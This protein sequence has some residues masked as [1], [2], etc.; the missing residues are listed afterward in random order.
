MIRKKP[1]QSAASD[2]G[3]VAGA[4]EAPTEADA[5]T[6]ADRAGPLHGPGP[7]EEPETHEAAAI[8]DEISDQLQELEDLKE[9]HLRLAAEFENYRKRTRRELA[10]AGERGQAS[11]VGK[12]L[13]ALDDLGR[14][15]DIPIDS[16][17]V[18]A[19]HEG[20]ALVERKLLKALNDAGLAV[21]EADGEPFD[22][23]LHDALLSVPTSDPDE[24]DTVSQVVTTGYVFRDR[25]LRPAKVVV[26]N[27]E[28]TEDVFGRQPEAGEDPDQPSESHEG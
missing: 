8:S 4:Q 11:L 16:T 6:V 28:G 27:L 13:D 25:L 9:R 12:L 17:T 7:A 1:R 26:K 10:E 2:P 22:P 21:V 14:V 24:D 18:E 15:A 5:E 23:N 20:V 3:D 19:L